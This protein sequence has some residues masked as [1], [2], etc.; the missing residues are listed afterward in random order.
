MK[1]YEIPVQ[2]KIL[3]NVTDNSSYV[4]FHHIDGA[5]SYCVTEKN[6]VVHLSANTELVEIEE[7]VYKL[8]G[9]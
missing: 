9:I 6:N 4:I 5:Y 3:V 8:A 7:Y 1:L 2:S